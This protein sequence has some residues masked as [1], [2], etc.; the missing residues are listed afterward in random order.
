MHHQNSRHEYHILSYCHFLAT[1][2]E[3]R[4]WIR[5]S[6]SARNERSPPSV[7]TRTCGG[8]TSSPTPALR[9]TL[10]LTRLSCSLTT[11]SWAWTFPME[12]SEWTQSRIKQ[13]KLLTLRIE[14]WLDKCSQQHGRQMGMFRYENKV[15]TP[16]LLHISAWP[17]ATWRTPRESQPPPSTS[18]QCL[19]SWTWVTRLDFVDLHIGSQSVKNQAAVMGWGGVT[20]PASTQPLQIIFLH[21]VTQPS[22]GLIDYDQLEKTARLFRPRLIIAGTSAYARLLDYARMK[23]VGQERSVFAAEITLLYIRRKQQ[24]ADI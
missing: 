18:N 24:V 12:D 4:L 11:E 7:W 6:C 9:P 8:S 22:T 5:S 3:Q 15:E 17:T 2:E 1:M 16:H 23:K 10:Q 21:P 20:P 19:I 14:G 13:N